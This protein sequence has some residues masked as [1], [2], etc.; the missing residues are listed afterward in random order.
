MTNIHPFGTGALASSG[1]YNDGTWELWKSNGT[2]AGTTMVKDLDPAGSSAPGLFRSHGSIVLFT[3]KPTGSLTTKLYRTD[4]TS[5][6][7]SCVN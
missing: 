5:I 6:R 3:A 4:G 2:A 7:S 1:N